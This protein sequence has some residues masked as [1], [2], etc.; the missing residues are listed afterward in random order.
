[1]NVI[2]LKPSKLI[3]DKKYIISKFPYN[4]KEYIKTDLKIGMFKKNKNDQ[5]IF[6]F[7][8]YKK[9]K[10][11]DNTGYTKWYFYTPFKILEKYD[12][13]IQILDEVDLI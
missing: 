12:D 10:K 7:S 3:N 11:Y 13:D 2:E 8:K 6:Y 4:K 5:S 9:Y 1:M